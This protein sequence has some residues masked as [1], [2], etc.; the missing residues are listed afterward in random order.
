MDQPKKRELA[1]NTAYRPANEVHPLPARA[2]VAYQ[3]PLTDVLETGPSLP[4]TPAC[5]PG[6][7][8]PPMPSPR[9]ATL[10]LPLGPRPMVPAWSAHSEGAGHRWQR[11]HDG[12]LMP[13]EVQETFQR[14]RQAAQQFGQTTRAWF[15]EQATNPESETQRAWGRVKYEF[16]NPNSNFRLGVSALGSRM[17]DGWESLAG[18]HA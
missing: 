2:G 12:N 16:G 3:S 10:A 4:S 11:H 15:H 9:S 5:V 13:P 7:D 8:S 18:H 1:S 17:A 14:Q 6:T